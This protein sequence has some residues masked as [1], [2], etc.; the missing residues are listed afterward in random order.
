MTDMDPALG[1]EQWRPDG[2]L[3]PITRLALQTPFKVGP[4]NSYVVDDDPLTLVDCGPLT[5]QAWTDLVAGLA[6]LGRRPEEVG[7]LIITHGHAD[8]WGLAARIV[9]ASGAEVW[10]HR[11]L[12]IWM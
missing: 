3:P 4:V 9:A 10:A 7:R 5:A 1:D 2:P 11:R 6:A 12:A 8:H